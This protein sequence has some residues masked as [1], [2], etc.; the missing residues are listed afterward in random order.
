MTPNLSR[1]SAQLLASTLEMVR[2]LDLKDR[3]IQPVF[4]KTFD[5]L[6]SGIDDASEDEIALYRPPLAKLVGQIDDALNSTQAIL[7]LFAKLRADKTVMETRFDQIEKLVKLVAAVRKRLSEEAAQARQLDRDVEQALVAM[8]KSEIAVEAE[9]GALQSQMKTMMKTIAYVDAETPKLENA[10]RAAFAKKDQKALTEARKTL[11][12]WLPVGAQVTALKAD[13]GKYLKAHPDL[14]RERKA[15]AQWLLDDL[16]RAADS[17]KRLEKA[18]RELV[19]LGQVPKEE[20]APA[21][22]LGHAEVEKIVKTLGV[23][24][25]R[26]DLRAKA[27]KI[28]NS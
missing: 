24:G 19:A 23:E 11:I 21:P 17:M 14:D 5:G 1:E 27:M 3:K 18:V 22:K 8:R 16:Q 12:D 28:V 9:L 13:V 7:Q 2:L 15:E 25:D 6:K 4:R 20:K 10:A 26:V